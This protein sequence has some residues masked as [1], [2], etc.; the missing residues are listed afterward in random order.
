MQQASRHCQ[1][2]QDE[3]HHHE[4]CLQHIRLQQLSDLPADLYARGDA[5]L[6]RRRPATTR[7]R[8]DAARRTPGRSICPGR[9]RREIRTIAEGEGAGHFGLAASDRRRFRLQS[10]LVLRP[11]DQATAAHYE[12]IIGLA[13]DLSSKMVLYHRRLAGGRHEPRQ[14]G[15]AYSLECLRS[16]AACAADHD[17]VVAIE[18]TTADTNLIDTAERGAP[19]DA[20]RRWRPTSGRCS[21][22]SMS[23]MRA[24]AL[25]D[26]VTAMGGDLVNV[27]AAD[28][29][30]RA[31]GDGE[32]DWDGLL[33]ALVDEQVIPDT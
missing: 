8:S 2:R 13:A 29:A 22:P 3:P 15:W 20:R 30:R 7:P 12:E 33:A 11:S 14:E 17:I 16:V 24:R 1:I 28:T 21:T 9:R 6:D 10:V 4:T 32:F 18:P 5:A 23:T 19:H 25:S 27:H 26:Y 31:I